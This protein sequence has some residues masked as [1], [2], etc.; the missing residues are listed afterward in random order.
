MIRFFRRVRQRLL[1]E[2]NTRRYLMYAVATAV[3]IAVVFFVVKGCALMP[4]NDSSRG[5]EVRVTVTRDF[6]R[7]L[8]KDEEVAVR[9]S[10]SAM[11]ALLPGKIL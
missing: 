6:G 3:L 4:W 1:I 9:S 10:G 5:T 8:L 7:E 2:K 11:D